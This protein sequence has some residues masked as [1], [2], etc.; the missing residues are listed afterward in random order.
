MTSNPFLKKLGFS[1][2]DRLV[3]IHTDDIGMCHA[4]VQAFKDLSAAGTITSGAVMVP[5]PWFPAVAR[6]CREDPE[7]DMGVHATLNAEWESY[8]WGPVSTRDEASGLLDTDGYFHQWHQA[9]YDNAK[10]EA[11]AR[12]V[13]A[14]IERALAA[15]I[16]VTHVDSHMGTIMSPL[17][18]QSYLQAGASRLLP[19][20][21]PRQNA[22][23]MDMM[24]ASPEEMQTY[25]PIL[26]QLEEMG[27]LMVDGLLSMPLNEPSEQKQMEL[28]RELFGELPMGITHFILHPSIDTPELRALA[29]DWE[30]RVANYRVFMSDELKSCLENEDIKL[31]GYRPIRDV[32]MNS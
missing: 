18:V 4:S 19:N 30:S 7:I 12:E 20:L 6:M 21:L 28:A 16:D 2:T 17:F 32:M 15:G 26:Q 3:I 29:P 24:G 11:V 22:K 13:N 14:Q 27:M 5:C 25:A 1:D 8:R 31:I 10:P 23:G 9:V